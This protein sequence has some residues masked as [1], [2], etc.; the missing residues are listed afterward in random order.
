MLD[1]I[2]PCLQ[3]V[4]GLGM[5]VPPSTCG[6]KAFI[7]IW[8]AFIVWILICGLQVTFEGRVDG[9]ILVFNWIFGLELL[10]FVAALAAFNPIGFHVALSHAKSGFPISGVTSAHRESDPV[11]V[12]GNGESFR[13]VAYVPFFVLIVVFGTRSEV[14]APS[15]TY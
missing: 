4:W 1:T 3:G 14:V 6:I 9:E 8:L 15:I 11:V 13:T 5:Q 2:R 7:G 12:K 10:D